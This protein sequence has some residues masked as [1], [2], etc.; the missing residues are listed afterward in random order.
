MSRKTLLPLVL[1]ATTTCLPLFAQDAAPPL[2]AADVRATVGDWIVLRAATEGRVVRWKSLD[3]GLRLA[4]PELTLRD[5]HTTLATAS[6]PGKYRVV[7][8]TARGDVPSEIVEF[9]VI[10]EA[11]TPKPEPKPPE[12]AD[13]LARKIREAL[14][15]DPGDSAKKREHAN[16]LAGFYAAMARHV[17]TRQVATIGELLSD[18]RSAIPA[19]LPEDAIPATRK[20]CGEEVARI[21]GADPAKPIDADLQSKLVDLFKRLANLLDLP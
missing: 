15:A 20:V 3:R 19:L 6:R 10:V 14:Q 17:A 8:V 11:E 9:L 18:Y 4:P 21:T 1:V 12:P 16:T 5:P 13:P 2:K 7:C